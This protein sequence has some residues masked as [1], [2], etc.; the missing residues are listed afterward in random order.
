MLEN[1]ANV[2][3]FN[4]ER[5]HRYVLSRVIK[6]LPGDGDF[7]P[8][9]R[10]RLLFV[11]LNP[12]T[13]DE[14]KLDPTVGKCAKYADAWGYSDLAVVNLFSL[15]STDPRALKGDL[16]PEGDPD[17]LFHIL[18]QASLADTVVVAYG[19][20]GGYQG[21]SRRVL[22]RLLDYHARLYALGLNLT[23]H[24]VHPL[25]QCDDSQFFPVVVTSKGTLEREG[26]EARQEKNA[27][28]NS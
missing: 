5:T 21:R 19:N 7:G 10:L 3:T 8:P 13:A 4:P 9:E 15:R 25:Y 2:C 27:H 12:S 23:G 17:N 16:H 22:G 24:P 11:M 28:S 14:E 18:H 6:S 1:V 26:N 20:H